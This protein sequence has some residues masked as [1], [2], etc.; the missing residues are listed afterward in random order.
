[1]R[2]PPGVAK[3]AQLPCPSLAIDHKAGRAAECCHLAERLIVQ[4]KAD[5]DGT[6]LRDE[7]RSNK[8]HASTTYALFGC[9]RRAVDSE[10]NEAIWPMHSWKGRNWLIAAAM[11]KYA[12]GT[13]IV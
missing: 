1:V 4:A 10:S 11:L 12:G 8:T 3:F 13:P 2:S 5:G 9:T 7:S 6:E